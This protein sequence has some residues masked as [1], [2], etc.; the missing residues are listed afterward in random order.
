MSFSIQASSSSAFVFC[1]E[2]KTALSL[3]FTS[4]NSLDNSSMKS[5]TQGLKLAI[6][7]LVLS[8]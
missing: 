5:R 7:E 1:N 8:V 3:E 2:T 4:P 6:R